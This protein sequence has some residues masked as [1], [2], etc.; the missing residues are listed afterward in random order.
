MSMHRTEKT[1]QLIAKIFAK[2]KIN[3]GLGAAAMA[4][5]LV[6]MA[7]HEQVTREEFLNT[8]AELYDT[9]S[10]KGEE[11]GPPN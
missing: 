5:L 3:S 1:K 8:L 11:D 10:G 6:R 4:E 9:M 7:L 2:H